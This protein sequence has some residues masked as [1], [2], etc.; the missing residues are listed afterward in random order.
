V[1]IAGVWPRLGWEI[2]P[3]TDASAFRLRLRAPDGTHIGRT[4]Q[5]TQQALHLVETTVGAEKI[6]LSLGYVGM[7]HSN[8]PINAVYQW[9]RGPE[10]AILYIGLRDDA[11]VDVDQLKDQ[12]R[13]RLARDLPD[14][15]ASFEPADIV[16]EVMSFGSPTRRRRSCT[17]AQ[18]SLKPRP[19]CNPRRR[20]RRRPACRSARPRR[21][22]P[23]KKPNFSDG[24]R[25]MPA[26]SNLSPVARSVLSLP[27]KS[28]RNIS[29]RRRP[30]PKPARKNPR[31]GR[32]PVSKP[33]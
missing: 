8:F 11:R 13:S 7:V 14:V 5:I 24:S 31:R 1:G 19:R 16:N 28:S 17:R 29:P 23:D 3:A 10:E 33:R 6:A 26:R 4:E 2:F 30:W 21:S 20:P 18:A 9:S 32:T 27:R 12:L 22:S 25:S 15:R